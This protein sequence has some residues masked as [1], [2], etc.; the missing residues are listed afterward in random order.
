[1]EARGLEL[2]DIQS[3]PYFDMVDMIDFYPHQ[4]LNLKND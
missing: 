4:L 3:F 1:M 2:T